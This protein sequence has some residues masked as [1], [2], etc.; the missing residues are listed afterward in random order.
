MVPAGKKWQLHFVI[1][2]FSS[3]NS[4][5]LSLSISAIYYHK[6][7]IFLAQNHKWRLKLTFF[8]ANVLSINSNLIQS[9]H[10]V[11]PFLLDSGKLHSKPSH[12]HYSH[13]PLLH[14]S[15]YIIPFNPRETG[16]KMFDEKGIDICHW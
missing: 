3:Q 1:P 2:K 9:S 7:S 4:L 6:I 14:Y 13:L 11:S 12:L 5:V 8:C 10:S 15:P 16:K